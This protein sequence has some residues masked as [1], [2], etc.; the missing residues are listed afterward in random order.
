MYLC[1]C[2]CVCP[3]MRLCLC[4]CLCLYMCMCPCL[5]CSCVRPSLK[6]VGCRLS[7]C[8]FLLHAYT[9]GVSVGVARL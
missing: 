1:V 6:F 9:V 3:R 2:P 4:M 7:L 5:G 8:L